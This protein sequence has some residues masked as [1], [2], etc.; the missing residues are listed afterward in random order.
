MI[1]GKAVPGGCCTSQIALDTAG[2]R[3]QEIDF[4]LGLGK[5]RSFADN[6][7]LPAQRGV[8]NSSCSSRA[9]VLIAGGAALQTI[10]P[11]HETKLN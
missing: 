5:F 1:A 2:E 4:T 6:L 10:F 8:M 7:S 3:F 9:S 11:A